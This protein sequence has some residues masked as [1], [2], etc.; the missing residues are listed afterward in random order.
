MDLMIQ[1]PEKT[2]DKWINIGASA[3]IIHIESTNEIEK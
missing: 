2:I 1:N 3:L